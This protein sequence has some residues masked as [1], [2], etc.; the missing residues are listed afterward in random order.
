MFIAM[1]CQADQ[2]IKLFELVLLP[3]ICQIRFSTNEKR[4]LKSQADLGMW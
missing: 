3:N 4:D 2:N 1:Q